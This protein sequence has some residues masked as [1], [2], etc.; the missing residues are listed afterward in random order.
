M[1]DIK[2]ISEKTLVVL[3][4]NHFQCSKEMTQILIL[5]AKNNDTL[6]DLKKTVTR[7]I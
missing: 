2:S 7:E 1:I 3:T 4:C 5:S 6:D